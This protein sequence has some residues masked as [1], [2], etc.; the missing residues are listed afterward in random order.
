[1]SF[2]MVE[3]HL[4]NVLEEGI[5]RLRKK[6]YLLNDVFGSLL[7]GGLR[8]KCG[9]KT[10]NEIRD[11]FINNDIPVTTA[12]NANTPAIPC[13]TINLTSSTEDLAYKAMGDHL[14]VEID[15]EAVEGPPRILSSPFYAQSYDPETGELIT[16]KISGKFP[17]KVGR[18]I[19]DQTSGESY[20]I[21]GTLFNEGKI[22]TFSIIDGDGNIPVSPNLTELLLV[23]TASKEAW[24]RGAVWFDETYDIRMF[25]SGNQDQVIWLYYI[26]SYILFR[27][28]SYFEEVGIENQ[29]VSSGE[30]A[31]DLGKQPNQ[32][33]SRFIR[34]RGMV[35]HSW[36]EEM[37][38]ID[39]L[40]Y[41]LSV[42][43]TNE[44]ND[45]VDEEA[46]SE[47]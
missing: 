25:G 24:R 44:G 47:G 38:R 22:Y 15:N 33:W 21:A 19:L 27:N 26:I 8:K 14:G 35:E 43:S 7:V 34:F 2:G 13:V 45:I 1:M 37:G 3:Y 6:P 39:D 31:R 41:S 28:K 29:S 16:S 32:V 23:A 12:F 5:E 30:I 9:Q 42:G 36:L 20:G 10:I 17:I 11:F 46:L 18:R 40:D 4:R